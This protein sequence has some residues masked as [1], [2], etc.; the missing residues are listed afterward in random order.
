MVARKRKTVFERPRERVALVG[1]HR[2]EALANIAGRQNARLLAQNARRPAV[3][4]HGNNGRRVGLEGKQC[5]DGHR[6]ARAATDDH[7]PYRRSRVMKRLGAYIL[8]ELCKRCRRRRVQRKRGGHY[9]CTLVSPV[10]SFR[11]D[12]AKGKSRCVTLTRY[13]RVHR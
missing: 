2:D 4:S 9:A 8:F 5:A 12:S 3:I 1:G 10:S 13:P 11:T 7:G 6:R